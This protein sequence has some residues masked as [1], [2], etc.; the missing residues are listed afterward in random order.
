MMAQ[1]LQVT[2]TNLQTAMT[3][4]E[5][6]LLMMPCSMERLQRDMAVMAWNYTRYLQP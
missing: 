3:A 2:F 1:G 5:R 4:L 6:S